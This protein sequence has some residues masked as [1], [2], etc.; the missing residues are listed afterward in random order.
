[1][2]AGQRNELIDFLVASP[3]PN[4]PRRSLSL[5]WCQLRAEMGPVPGGS[6]GL[7]G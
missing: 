1:M 6:G 3:G 7:T 2:I 5:Y 4:K